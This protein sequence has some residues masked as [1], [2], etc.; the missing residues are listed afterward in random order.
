MST[1]HVLMTAF[2]KA[3]LFFL[4]V[5]CGTGKDAR[6]WHNSVKLAANS[7]EILLERPN[8]KVSKTEISV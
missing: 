4:P 3:S 6:G 8:A 5:K 7:N 2:A 1:T